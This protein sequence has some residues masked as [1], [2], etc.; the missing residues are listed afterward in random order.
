VNN[1]VP[2]IGTMKLAEVNDQAVRKL[3]EK[4]RKPWLGYR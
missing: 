1:V 2:F 4:P 3:E